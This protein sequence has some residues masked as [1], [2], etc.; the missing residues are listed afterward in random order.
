VEEEAFDLL[1]TDEIVDHL[2]RRYDGV[3]L[4]GV[5]SLDSKRESREVAWRGGNVLALGLA[6]LSVQRIN[7]DESIIEEES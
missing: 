2:K 3:L 7:A 6:S 1:T 5:R 4:A